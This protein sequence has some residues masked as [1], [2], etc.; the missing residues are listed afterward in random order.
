MIIVRFV[1]I[2]QFRRAA[3]AERIPPF[4]GTIRFAYVILGCISVARGRMPEE[5]MDAL[6][7]GREQTVPALTAFVHPCTACRASFVGTLGFITRGTETSPP[8]FPERRLP[9]VAVTIT[10]LT[11]NSFSVT[12]LDLPV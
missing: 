8:P 11:G 5:T 4:F 1:V 9:G 6:A 10:T 3:Y 7:R 12:R 2:N